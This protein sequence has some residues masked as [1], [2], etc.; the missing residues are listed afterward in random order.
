LGSKKKENSKGKGGGKLKA[1]H[2]KRKKKGR[3]PTTVEFNS[4]WMGGTK[5]KKKNGFSF[6]KGK[7]LKILVG[8]REGKRGEKG[9]GGPNPSE[10]RKERS[11]D[12]PFA[13]KEGGG[14]FLVTH[15]LFAPGGAA[16]LPH[17]EGKS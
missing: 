11:P 1:L 7:R 13:P 3:I 14:P 9:G 15:P 2:A 5:K 12:R 4:H 16:F 8:P 17:A 6:R 10:E